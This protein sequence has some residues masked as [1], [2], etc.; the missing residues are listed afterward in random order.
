MHIANL[1]SWQTN[2]G[3]SHVAAATRGE[4]LEVEAP[5]DR[6]CLERVPGVLRRGMMAIARHSRDRRRRIDAPRKGPGLTAQCFT[7]GVDSF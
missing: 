1:K 3:T 5:V 7:G 4:P 2:A 6:L